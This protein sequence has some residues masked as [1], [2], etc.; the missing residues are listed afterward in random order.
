M[1]TLSYLL[2]AT[3]PLAWGGAIQSVEV[4][5]IAPGEYRL[6]FSGERLGKVKVFAD[7]D[8]SRITSHAAIAEVTTSPVTIHVQE[9]NERIYVHLQSKD[10]PVRTAATRSLNLAGAANFRDLG[11][12]KTADGHWTRWGQVFRSNNLASLTEKDYDLLASLNLKLVCDVRVNSERT[13]Q[14]TRWQG[15]EPEFFLTPIGDDATIQNASATFLQNSAASQTSLVSETRGYEQFVSEYAG[16]YDKVFHRILAGGLP[17]VFHCSAGRD[18]TG[19]FAAML[20]TMLNVPR[21]TVVQDYMLT[22]KYL[23]SDT[24]IDKMA[25]D[26]QKSMHLPQKPPIAL[27]RE[28][29]EMKRSVIESTFRV[30]D[31]RYGSF[32]NFRRTMLHISDA[33][34]DQLRRLLT[35]P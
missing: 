2:L 15:K 1:R 16:Q 24:A 32:D 3:V 8:P 4:E 25:S 22:G 21:E 26:L 20:L 23:L 11:G 29:L 28:R 9:R 6:E 31:E 35:Q 12:Y 5:K 14:P 10:G 34:Q 17:S 13:A 18:R 7:T 27:M 33:E 30:I 19:T